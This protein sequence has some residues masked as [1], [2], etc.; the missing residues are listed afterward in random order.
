LAVATICGLSYLEGQTVSI[1]AN[2]EV[3]D[4]QVVTSGII[5]LGDSYSVVHVGLPFYADLQ[6]LN[7]VLP[8]KDMN[9]I[10]GRKAKVNNVTFRLRDSR[11]GYVG[12]D[13]DNLYD[14][15]SVDAINRSSGQN[16]DE[17][18]LFTGDVRQPLGAGRFL[19]NGTVFYRQVNPLPITIGAIM[20]EVTVGGYVR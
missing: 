20:P 10:F 1:L 8:L 16:I 18:D 13:E 11:G 3:L 6:T 9:S 19:G 4:Q 7:V 15:F 14:A 12:P 2:G 5:N 17:F